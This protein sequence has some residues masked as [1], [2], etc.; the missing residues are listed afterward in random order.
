MLR[1]IICRCNY[2]RSS[3]YYIISSLHH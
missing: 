3:Q 2:I 1:T